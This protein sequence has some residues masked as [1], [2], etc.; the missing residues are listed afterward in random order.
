MTVFFQLSISNEKRNLTVQIAACSELLSG[1]LFIRH[2]RWANRQSPVGHSPIAGGPFAGGPFASGPFAG[3]PFTG[4]PLAGG[5]FAGGPFA[6]E[7][8]AGGPFAGGPLD[9]PTCVHSKIAHNS[10]DYK[11]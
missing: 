5:P 4:G 3:G 7:P 2:P 1:G 10:Q 8:F 11:I 9:T 6:G